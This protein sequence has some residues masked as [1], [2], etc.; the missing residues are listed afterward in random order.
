VRRLCM[1]TVVRWKKGTCFEVSA[2]E[3][4]LWCD[5]PKEDGGDNLGPE[6]LELL[7]A[8]LAT[9]IAVYISRNLDLHGIERE[10]L[11]VQI[12]REIVKEHPRR[13]GA[14]KIDIRIPA[15][16]DDRRRKALLRAAR[17]CTIHHTFE[18]PPQID[19]DLQTGV[20]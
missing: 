3:H 15:Q 7:D 18:Q 10:G 1:A 9:C 16:V 11:T 6:P 4:T 14:F 19:I 5:Q 8:S 12:R 13:V 2:R 20:G 17:G